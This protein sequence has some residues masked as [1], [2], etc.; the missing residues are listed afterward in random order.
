MY[1]G[2]YRQRD[3]KTFFVYNLRSTYITFSIH[4]QNKTIQENIKSVIVCV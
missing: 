4:I 1:V 3:I 2:S